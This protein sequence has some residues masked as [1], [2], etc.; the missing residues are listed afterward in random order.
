MVDSR[1]D[2]ALPQRVNDQ[3]VTHQS[4]QIVTIVYDSVGRLSY[5]LM[6]S[7]VKYYAIA[8]WSWFTQPVMIFFDENIQACWLVRA[9]HA[10]LTK[11]RILYLLGHVTVDKLNST[12]RL[13]KITTDNACIDLLTMDV[14]SEAEVTFYGINFISNGMKMHGNLRSKTTELTDKVKTTYDMHN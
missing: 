11:N 10:R 14:S 6:A 1:D 13:E 2:M 4:T 8:Q 9:D 12:L 3:A 7:D 5:K